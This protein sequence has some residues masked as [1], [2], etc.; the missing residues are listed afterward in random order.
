MESR[1]GYRPG[2]FRIKPLPV[3]GARDRGQSRRD[4]SRPSARSTNACTFARRWN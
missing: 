1:S 4:R 3:G 2:P